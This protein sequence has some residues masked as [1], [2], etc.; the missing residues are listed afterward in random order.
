MDLNL[1]TKRIFTELQ[2]DYGGQVRGI[3]LSSFLQMLELEGRTCTM[4]I[5]TKGKNGFLYMIEGALIDARYEQLDGK[6]AALQIL[7]WENV[8]I[9]LDYA[10]VVRPR[11]IN[12]HLM[13][14]L[15]ESGR[16]VDEAKSGRKNQRLHDRFDC[17]VAVDYYF[18]DWTYH[19]FLRD[20]SLGGAY[21]ETE[22]AI[23]AG[24]K[25][26]LAISAPNLP[27]CSIEGVVARRDAKGIGIQFETLTHQQTQIIDEMTQRSGSAVDSA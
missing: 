24:Q 12:V 2:I 16:I 3:H 15:M 19:C 21:V 25:I 1:L 18:S 23:A 17:L 20:I 11:K 6:A 5:S 7:T 27:H 9:D 4:S 26:M 13:A 8:I 10:P 14:V 22:Q